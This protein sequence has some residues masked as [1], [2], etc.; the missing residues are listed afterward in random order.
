MERHFVPHFTRSRPESCRSDVRHPA[1]MQTDGASAHCDKGGPLAKGGGRW[2]QSATRATAFPRSSRSRSLSLIL[3]YCAFQVRSQKK[4][5]KLLPN[6]CCSKKGAAH[7]YCSY[8]RASRRSLHR[9]GRTCTHPFTTCVVNSLFCPSW[10]AQQ[11][12][13]TRQPLSQPCSPF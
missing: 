1:K 11:H 6:S 12:R 9:A 5:Y 3:L 4:L 13:A 2:R 8:R 7:E 10:Y